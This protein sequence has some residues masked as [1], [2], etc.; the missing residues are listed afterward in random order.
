MR[1]CDLCSHPAPRAWLVQLLWLVGG[2]S[3]VACGGSGA[4]FVDA[5]GVGLELIRPWTGPTL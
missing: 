5:A 4:E 2:P 3:V 1:E